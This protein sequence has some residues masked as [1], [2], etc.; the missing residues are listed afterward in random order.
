MTRTAKKERTLTAQEQLL[1]RHYVREGGTEDRIP[2]AARKLKIPPER[3]AAILRRIH[4]REEVARRL[5]MLQFEQAR[6]DARDINRRENEEEEK[7]RVTEA[8]VYRQLNELI[9]AD[10]KSL[11]DGHRMKAEF[12]RLALVVTGTIRDGRTERLLPPDSQPGQHGPNIYTSMFGQQ[13]QKMAG[14]DDAADLYPDEPLPVAEPAAE[15]KAEPPAEPTTPA[16]PQAIL[17]VPVRRKS[18]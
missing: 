16:Q 8:K 14:E 12:L 9:E 7:I 2:R 17:E 10:P 4:V 6:L 5:A 15:K 13:A 18:R 11:T 1:I 3:A